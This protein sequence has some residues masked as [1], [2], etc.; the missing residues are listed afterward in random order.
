MNKHGQ[1]ETS[2]LGLRG[3]V[4]FSLIDIHQTPIH[5]IP[6]SAIR[7]GQKPSATAFQEELIFSTT[8]KPMKKKKKEEP[9]E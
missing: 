5:G 2:K 6:K 1:L 7:V 8:R 9:H 3:K 4:V